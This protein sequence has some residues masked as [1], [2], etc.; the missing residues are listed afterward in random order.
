MIVLGGLVMSA[1]AAVLLGI[2]PALILFAPLMIVQGLAQ[3]TGWSPLCKNVAQFFTIGERGRILGLWT[4]NYAFGGLAAAPFIGWI[5]YG[6]FDSWRVAFLAGAGVVLVVAVLFAVLQRNKPADVGLPPIDEYRAD[7]NAVVVTERAKPARSIREALLAAVGDRMVLL[8]G[9]SYFLL[10][11]ARYA[12][13]LWGPVIVIERI[14]GA[15]MLKAI[16]LPV[17]FG[18]AGICAPIIIGL[19]SDKL[20]AARRIPPAVL[21]LL[22]LVAALALF[23]PLTATGS[24]PMMAIMLALIGFTVYAA[25]AMISCVAAVDFGTSEHAG[26]SAGFINGCGS[27]GAVL[28]G[29]LP[30]YLGTNSLFFG[31]AGAALVAALLLAPK[32]KSTPAAA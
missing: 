28:G 10:K 14:P 27:I 22:A 11:P 17:A 18:A 25:D 15:G 4:T 9:A 21:S 26:A 5:A 7:E 3:S 29:L 31:F 6:M 23:V 8:L 20:F 13:L 24:V 19:V 16:V 2:G 30:G 32:W 12:I 1:V